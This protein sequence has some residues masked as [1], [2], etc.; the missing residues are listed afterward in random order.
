LL[1][2]AAQPSCTKTKRRHERTCDIPTIAR[3]ALC[4]AANHPSRPR[5]I[6]EIIRQSNGD[7]GL[8]YDPAWLDDGFALSDDMPLVAQLWT[9]VHRTNRQPGAPGALDD[10]RPD[11]WGEK[12]IRYL[13]RPGAAVFDYLYFA[14]DERFGAL[15]ASASNANC[16]PFMARPL[17]RLTDANA[18]NDAIRIIESGEGE[19]QQ[20]QRAMVGS[21]GSLGGAKPKAVIAI[22]AE[23]W[24]LKFFNAEPFDHPLV[25]H[26]TMTLA[27]QAGIHVAPTFA[28]RLQAEHALAIKRFDRQNGSRVH[29]LSACTLL[30]SEV[31]E[32]MTPEYGY[33]QLARALRRSADPRTLESQLHELFRRMVF[34]ILVA[35]TDD[36]EKNHALLCRMKGRTMTLELSPAYDMVPTGSGAFEHQFMISDTSREPSLAQAMSAAIH[37]EMPPLAAAKE[38]IRI[39][40]VVNT[41]QTHFRALGVTERDMHQ[42]AEIIDA[43]AL[44]EQRS[45]FSLQPYTDIKARRRPP[46]GARAF[47]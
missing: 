25:E 33:P 35:N 8:K 46:S 24:V 18:L 41:W 37:F 13:Y 12:V 14:G 3:Q 45:A 44:L 34:N 42:M 36:H 26:A 19:L 10:A 5:L 9:P 40:A 6:G 23:E 43:P 1:P 2:S 47:R 7:V 30:R 39:I 22:D 29:C 27:H 11:R 28:V 17:P 15:G 31:P 38:I 16:I 32:T 21:G 20:Q 4:L